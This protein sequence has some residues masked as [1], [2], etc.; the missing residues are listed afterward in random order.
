VLALI[1]IL[2][3]IAACKKN[4]NSA[5]PAIRFIALSPDTI[6]SGYAFDTSKLYFSFEDGDGDLGNDPT[7]GEYDIYLHDV[8]DTDKE[9]S[10]RFIFPDIPPEA[11]D[12]INGMKG[13]GVIALQAAL[14]KKRT[15]SL[16][17]KYGDTTQFER[18]VKDK[19]QNKIN[20]ITTTR[21]YIRP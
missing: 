6:K 20:V 11:N 15:D 13:D 2:I 4:K 17:F 12:P 16:H 9:I 14:I 5:I 3:G 1:T 21:L 19:A 7:K 8:R 18:W 10:Y